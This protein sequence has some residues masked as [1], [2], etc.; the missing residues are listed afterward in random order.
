MAWVG[1]GLKEGLIEKKVLWEE[2]Y[3]KEQSDGVH[4]RH[5]SKL[6]KEVNHVDKTLI[7]FFLVHNSSPRQIGER[8]ED[9]KRVHHGGAHSRD[10]SGKRHGR[11]RGCVQ[12][13]YRR[14]EAIG[15][16][17]LLGSYRAYTRNMVGLK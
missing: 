1:D 11:D 10:A 2:I 6:M 5:A 8:D 9:A 16:A 15:I 17:S 12:W 13:R 7:P 14:Q 3:E 4:K